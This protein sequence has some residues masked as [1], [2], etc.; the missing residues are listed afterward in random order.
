MEMR[1]KLPKSK[2]NLKAQVLKFFFIV[3]QNWQYLIFTFKLLK[4]RVRS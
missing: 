1:L 3:C 2:E 4:M